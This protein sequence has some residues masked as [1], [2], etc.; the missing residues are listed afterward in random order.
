[1]YNQ[2]SPG[3]SIQRFCLQDVNVKNEFKIV[4]RLRPFNTENYRRQVFHDGLRNCWHS[5]WTRKFMV[6]IIQEQWAHFTGFQNKSQGFLDCSA[7]EQLF[8][9]KFH[10]TLTPIIL[11]I[12][13]KILTDG[14]LDSRTLSTTLFTNMS[15]FTQTP[16]TIAIIFKVSTVHR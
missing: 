14:Q 16:I 8:I 12:R 5:S 11:A 6:S 7:L 10:V 9:K 4:S 2:M 13:F 3:K 15:Q 1:M